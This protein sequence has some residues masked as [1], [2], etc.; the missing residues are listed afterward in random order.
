MNEKL[1]KR[2]SLGSFKKVT[3]ECFATLNAKFISEGKFMFTLTLLYGGFMDSIKL[4]EIDEKYITYLSGF[5][6][7]LFLNKKPGQHNERKYIGIVFQIDSFDYFAPISSF[8]Q[9]H[10]AMK[11]GI[12]LIKIKN[13]AVINLNNMFPVPESARKYVDI[14]NHPDLRY[15]SLLLAEYR[16]IKSIQKKIRK[17]AQSLYK[18]KLKDGNTSA[19]SK[20]C[21][22]FKSLEEASK[23]Y[24][25]SLHR[26]T[27]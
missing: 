13:Y 24:E 7:H 14:G 10:Y 22:D 17:N 1:I 2:T 15:R 25:N 18:I 11:E 8:K 9:K 16:Y 4:F 12:D 3:S 6:P 27:C 23:N 26:R 19:L 20:R 5:E 21:N